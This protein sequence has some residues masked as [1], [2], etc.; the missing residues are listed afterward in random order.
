MKGGGNRK[1][2]KLKVVQGTYRKDRAPEQ[3]PEFADADLAP[4]EHLEGIALATWNHLAPI[5]SEAG[6]FKVTDRRALEGYCHAYANMREAQRQLNIDGIVIERGDQKVRHPATGIFHE[7]S[8]RMNSFAAVLG[9]DPVARS[10]VNVG[11]GKDGGS[12]FGNL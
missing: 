9:L 8:G 10:R 5:L 7:S 11:K 4:P 12:P 2:T 3:E 1:P 6:V